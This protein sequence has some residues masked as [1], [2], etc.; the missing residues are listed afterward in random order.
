MKLVP[1]KLKLILGYVNGSVEVR[2][3][4]RLDIPLSR[5]YGHD[6]DT[7]SIINS[8]FFGECTGFV[9]MA[10][11]CTLSFYDSSALQPLMDIATT[12]ASR[13]IHMGD[14]S[15]HDLVLRA[16]LL[17]DV[18]EVS[19][20][21]DIETTN[22]TEKEDELKI[23]SES[24]TKEITII[25]KNRI[26][27]STNKKPVIYEQLF[28]EKQKSIEADLPVKKGYSLQEQKIQAVEDKRMK[29]EEIQRKTLLSK[30][31]NLREQFSLLKGQNKN[32]PEV[33]RLT[34]DKLIFDE[35]F[36]SKLNFEKEK[37]LEECR[38]EMEYDTHVEYV[39]TSKLKKYFLDELK[40]LPFRVLSLT[41]AGISVQSFKIKKPTYYMKTIDADI[42][43][44]D[45]D[46]LLEY[47][48]IVKRD[49]F[50]L[51]S[52]FDSLG[53]FDRL[54]FET[55]LP[56]I[57]AD[58]INS[59]GALFEKEEDMRV[60]MKQMRIEMEAQQEMERREAVELKR[61]EHVISSK[62]NRAASGDWE[63]YIE[64]LRARVRQGKRG[65]Y[66]ENIKMKVREECTSLSIEQLRQLQLKT[67]FQMRDLKKK[68]PELKDKGEEDSELKNAEKTVGDYKLKIKME[69][70]LNE[71]M[72]MSMKVQERKI[73]G[74]EGQMIRLKSVFNEKLK[75]LRCRKK[76]LV[77]RANKEKA[78]IEELKQV[79]GD[80][81]SH[82]ELGN[83]EMQEELEYP[84]RIWVSQY[85]TCRSQDMQ[86]ETINDFSVSIPK[87][88]STRTNVQKFKEDKK[89][90]RG[91][92]SRLKI[93]L[94]S[95][96]LNQEKKKIHRELREELM[97]V[98]RELLDLRGDRK[99]LKEYLKRGQSRVVGLLQE[100][101]EIEVF[102]NKD[103]KLAEEYYKKRD[104]LTVWEKEM[105]NITKN[106]AK[107]KKQD[108]EINTKLKEIRE[109]IR[110]KLFPG[111]EEKTEIV[112]EMFK[113]KRDKET[114]QSNDGDSDSEGNSDMEGQERRD[115]FSLFEQNE[116]AIEMA[117]KRYEMELKL[118]KY[119]EEKKSSILE[120][121]RIEKKIND[122]LGNVKETAKEISD[123][124]R[125]KLKR[126]YQLQSSLLLK[127][128][129]IKADM[130]VSSLKE[131]VLFSKTSKSQLNQQS[132]TLKEDYNERKKH[133][134][135]LN[136]SKK[137][138]G[139]ELLILKHSLKK[140]NEELEKNFQLKF[141][142][143]IDLSI[144][145]SLKESPRLKELK[146][147]YKTEEKTASLK[148]KRA[149][150]SLCLSKKELMELKSK[151]TDIIKKLTGLGKIQLKL[152]KILDSTNKQ[153]FKD[154]QGDEKENISKYKSD[155]KETIQ[156]MVNEL[157]LIKN[158]VRGLK[159]KGNIN[160]MITKSMHKKPETLAFSLQKNSHNTLHH[161][162]SG[163]NSKNSFKITSKK[164]K[165]KI[166]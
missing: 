161:Q 133:K 24:E 111:E 77:N 83:W 27:T 28:L 105:K 34:P 140:S 33:Y 131:V 42:D 44:M 7:G 127:V 78:R 70:E 69:F 19:I 41:K 126:V 94:L 65:D 165:T 99:V 14:D 159:L 122:S 108:T 155:L 13:M 142:E 67:K 76:K 163:S 128:E 62:E 103:N 58:S 147:E 114:G 52:F 110:D 137:W 20:D 154:E 115:W 5:F 38:K 113:D 152:N 106:I 84:H 15:G 160:N 97:A 109:K 60:F 72:K 95:E 116:E 66:F 164:S 48:L 119:R 117:K 45:G 145:D 46:Y 57:T 23:D 129:Q 39:G 1:D 136:N 121:S 74:L 153:I 61:G 37:I 146:K 2:G 151:N 18:E 21:S 139:K 6:Q 81:S 98:E 107:N 156:F 157:E 29:E 101:L 144:I 120:K 134:N 56:M 3:F 51:S 54:I 158:E 26:R 150:E 11:D 143:T 55:V 88:E 79:L 112:Y 22:P 93:R 50:R 82:W 75:R 118:K 85:R 132:K 43:K 90:T 17:L 4:P 71:D 89:K 63:E 80:E 104:T 12:S 25:D 9:S 141:G 87:R 100:M 64:S 73:I 124:F 68:E 32:L 59:N 149:K 36:L 10:S 8:G 96:K 40:V 162:H 92:V 47:Y 130:P 35:S 102:E 91:I 125:Q 86:I 30:V 166:S 49:K 123:L 31:E 16:R 53:D 135:Q 138:L 148:I